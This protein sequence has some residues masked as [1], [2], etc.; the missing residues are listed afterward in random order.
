MISNL[1]ITTMKSEILKL[2]V[3]RFLFIKLN[4]KSQNTTILLLP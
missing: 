1:N 3:F 4:T 2:L